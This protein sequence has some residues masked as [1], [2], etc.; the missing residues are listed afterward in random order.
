MKFAKLKGLMAIL[1][2]CAAFLAPMTADAVE[3]KYASIS[4]P[5][6]PWAKLI[7]A[8]VKNAAAKSNGELVIK[9]FLGGQ[10]GR[11]PVVIQQVARGRVDMGGFSLTATALVVPELGLLSAP[12]LWD[13]TKQ[14]ECALDNYLIAALQ[15]YFAKH[16]LINLGWGEAGYQEVF[17]KKP[18]LKAADYSGV[19]I[20][21]A[22]AK[23]S[24]LAFK[25]V[26]ANGVVLP[27]AELSGALQTGLVNAAEISTT[28][29]VLTGVIRLA[30]YVNKT[31]HIYL[32]T[33]TVI[34]KKSF[35]KLSESQQA[36]LLASPVPARMQRKTVRG[37]QAAM[38][39]KLIAAGGH[40]NDLD[41]GERDKL[42]AEMVKTYPALVKMIGGDAPVVW[43]EI[44]KAKSACSG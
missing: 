17:S 14:A 18:M 36:A 8:L 34:S 42:K 33:L 29:G 2:S 30:P 10:L 4:P 24:V 40:I 44:M 19:K 9:P 28:F 27:A 16:G 7:Q 35:D 41:P 32:P 15:P 22:P 26:G 39:K 23:G 20:R 13:S 6:S 11:E 37:V 12:F 21:V 31:D 1:I 5:N 38:T 3:L 43:K 25:A